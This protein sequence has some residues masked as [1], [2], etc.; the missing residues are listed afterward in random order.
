MKR[1]RA[2][3]LFFLLFLGTGPFLHSQD[4]GF[5]GINIGMSRNEVL[6][7]ADS[8]H[9]IT[10]PKNRDVEFFPVEDRKILSLSVEPEIP[11]IYLQFYSDKLYGITLTFNERYI[12]YLTLAGTLEAKYGPFSSLTPKWRKWT[13]GGI[14]IKVEKPAVVK[15]LALKEF[16]QVTGLR[17]VQETKEGERRKILLEGL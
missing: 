17:P 9:L 15:Y 4:I 14:E 5:M 10:V 12:D 2:W 8:N 6:T 7:Y 11:H 1:Y 13:I 16:L 3:I